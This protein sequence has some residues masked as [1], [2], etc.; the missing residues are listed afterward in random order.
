MTEKQL[1]EHSDCSANSVDICRGQQHSMKSPVANQSPQYYVKAVKNSTKK[2]NWDLYEGFMVKGKKHGLGRYTWADSECMLCMWNQGSCKEQETREA[3][4][5]H[6]LQRTRRQTQTAQADESRSFNPTPK[7][8]NSACKGQCV[9]CTNPTST[10]NC[11]CLHCLTSWCL[12]CE[13]QWKWVGFGNRRPPCHCIIAT[14]GLATKSWDQAIQNCVIEE[15]VSHHFKRRPVIATVNDTLLL[16]RSENAQGAFLCDIGRLNGQDRTHLIEQEM[17]RSYIKNYKPQPE[18]FMHLEKSWT[19]PPETFPV[20]MNSKHLGALWNPE[21]FTMKRVDVDSLTINN[22][23]VTKESIPRRLTRILGRAQVDVGT[24]WTSVKP[25]KNYHIVCSPRPV[26][27]VYCEESLENEMKQFFAEQLGAETFSTFI[28]SKDSHIVFCQAAASVDVETLFTVWL[29]V[30]RKFRSEGDGISPMELLRIVF[31]GWKSDPD[32]IIDPFDEP[33][34]YYQCK[35]DCAEFT[36]SYDMAHKYVANA[37]NDILKMAKRDPSGTSKVLIPIF[38]PDRTIPGF[39][40]NN[41]SVWSM[42]GPLAGEKPVGSMKLDRTDPQNARSLPVNF[43]RIKIYASAVNLTKNI[44][45]L[46]GVDVRGLTH[47]RLKYQG[48]KVTEYLNELVINWKKHAQVLM[49]FRIECTLELSD[50]KCNLRELRTQHTTYQKQLLQEVSATTTMSLIA[51]SDIDSLCRWCL[52]KFIRLSAGDDKK[53][54]HDQEMA[55]DML[56]SL[57]HTMGYHHL[58]YTQQK[59]ARFLIELNMQQVDMNSSENQ[60]T[61]LLKTVLP[62]S[63]FEWSDETKTSILLQAL[64]FMNVRKF[65]TKNKPESFVFRYMYKKICTATTNGPQCPW[66]YSSKKMLKKLEDQQEKT[67]ATTTACRSNNFETPIDL[68]LDVQARLQHHMQSCNPS[69]HNWDI[70]IIQNLIESILFKCTEHDKQNQNQEIIR[71]IQLKIA[72][73]ENAVQIHAEELEN[74]STIASWERGEGSQIQVDINIDDLFRD[75]FDSIDDAISDLCADLK[76]SHKT[77]PMEWIKFFEPKNQTFIKLKDCVY[78]SMHFAKGNAKC[79]FAWNPKTQKPMCIKLISNTLKNKHE[80]DMLTKLMKHTGKKPGQY[81]IVEYFGNEVRNSLICLKFEI[82]HPKTS[83]RKDLTNMTNTQAV[84]YMRNLL[85]ALDVIHNYGIT[86]RDIK[87]ENFVHHFQTNTF[88]LI[89]FGSA[90]YIE[91]NHGIGLLNAGTRGFKAPELLHQSHDANKNWFKRQ[92]CIDIWSAGIILM[93]LLTG[94]KDILTRHDELST[95]DC[96]AKHFEEIGNVVGKQAMKYLNVKNWNI[97]SDGCKQEG[98]TG[99]SAKAIQLCKRP[100]TPCDEA[101]DLLSQMLNVNPRE[102]ITSRAALKHPWLNPKELDDNDGPEEVDNIAN[103][104][105]EV[106][107]E[108]GLPN[109]KNWCYLNSVLQC[110][111]HTTE[112]TTFMIESKKTYQLKVDNMYFHVTKH[113]QEFLVSDTSDKQIQALMNLRIKLSR[114]DNKFD[115]TTQQDAG[116][117]CALLLQAMCGAYATQCPAKEVMEYAFEARMNCADCNATWTSIPEHELVAKL[118]VPNNYCLQTAINQWALATPEILHDATCSQCGRQSVGKATQLVLA[119]SVIILQ[120]KI[121]D[122]NGKKKGRPVRSIEGSTVKVGIHDYQIFAVV[123]HIGA[124]SMNG[125][126]ISYTEK[127]EVWV[128]F[129]DNKVTRN[130]NWNTASGLQEKETPYIFFLKKI[131]GKEQIAYLDHIEIACTGQQNDVQQTISTNFVN[132]QDVGAAEETYFFGSSHESDPTQKKAATNE[133]SH[134]KSIGCSYLTQLEA[135]TGSND[136]GNKTEKASTSQQNDIQ[137]SG[138][139]TVGNNVLVRLEQNVEW[140]MAILTGRKGDK[141]QVYSVEEKETRF[142]TKQNIKTLDWQHWTREFR[143]WT[144]AD[145]KTALVEWKTPKNWITK[146]GLEALDY[147]QIGTVVAYHSG[148]KENGNF[149]VAGLNSSDDFNCQILCVRNQDMT[150]KNKNKKQKRKKKDPKIKESIAVFLVTTNTVHK[151]QQLTWYQKDRDVIPGCNVLAQLEEGGN[152]TMAIVKQRT[153]LL[154]EV[155][156]FSMAKMQWISRANIK[157]LDW[158]YWEQEMKSWKYNNFKDALVQWNMQV[159]AKNYP[160]KGRGLEALEDFQVGTVVAEYFGYIANRDGSLYM[161]G[162]CPT[163]D[164]CM[165]Q[166]LNVRTMQQAEW[167]HRKDHCVTLGRSSAARFCIDGYATTCQTLDNVQDH[168]GVGWGALLNSDKKTRCNCTLLW[169]PHP[170]ICRIDRSEH[171]ETNECIA[172][173]LVTNKNVTKGDQLTWYYNS[174]KFYFN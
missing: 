126:Y 136:D 151:G 155:H 145:F 140:T 159:G 166:H 167:K 111:K 103:K 149:D 71:A 28:P 97:Y 16:V 172:A 129:N 141:I 130:K 110:L 87:P 63:D 17:V 128:C 59:H 41:K 37:H 10:E 150:C 62:A 168:G 3:E 4:K 104:T 51:I 96:N 47:K 64:K 29:K 6:V 143:S 138:S 60:P 109:D 49:S 1:H 132:N 73:K 82:V 156:S 94:K 95:N 153:G 15:V 112:L 118:A 12:N 139:F 84:T 148:C 142:V 8:K 78:A 121:F 160:D 147:C 21:M 2:D 117:V 56:L 80:I 114:L 108:T 91:D 70:N 23:R 98:K 74:H 42:F 55:T 38:G 173:F 125:H 76:I 83:L 162:Y 45:R 113:L 120:L 34:M 164:E 77:V 131:D 81:N 20:A 161:G 133:A 152:W 30:V 170:D 39:S 105:I 44:M 116:K 54:F 31:H 163:M 135:A 154:Y 14:D 90:V 36:A 13:K 174:N 69:Q 26:V 107:I 66:C 61:K 124:S 18:V 100:F 146:T 40:V 102:R 7:K 25:P 57:W 86:H 123:T 75:E 67:H 79:H 50:A 11:E 5:Q 115:G 158:D 24:A 27:M 53:K 165:R 144:C 171:L 72:N 33:G 101:L 46:S 127:N 93:S 68:A 65:T 32:F 19:L 52:K 85:K 48:K 99:W 89:D 88:R 58:A 134:V 169:V 9:F 119:P 22:F 137:H 92:P 157:I 106:I 122:I 43:K 35:Q